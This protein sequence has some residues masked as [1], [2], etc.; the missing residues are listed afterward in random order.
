MKK[1]GWRVTV[2]LPSLEH[3]DGNFQPFS[4]F[5]SVMSASQSSDGSNPGTISEPALWH[6]ALIAAEIDRKKASDC[7]A[8]GSLAELQLLAPMAGLPDG[9]SKAVA[10]L[11]EMKTRVTTRGD[12]DRFPLESTA[13]QC[14]RYVNWRTNENGSFPRRADF[15]AQA[16]R[17]VDILIPAL[18][19]LMLYHVCRSAVRSF[20]DQMYLGSL[21]LGYDGP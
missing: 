13:S 5:L 3:H 7:W 16:N 4:A 18:Q 17:L 2:N 8:L 20:L 1:L 15:A 14:R 21:F 9:L 19:K 6:A 10:L 12:D 11:E